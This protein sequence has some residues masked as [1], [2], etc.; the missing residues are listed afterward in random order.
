MYYLSANYYRGDDTN[1]YPYKWPWIIVIDTRKNTITTFK[2]DNPQN[3]YLNEA[4]RC[5][6]AL[7]V[8]KNNFWPD[9]TFDSDKT[10]LLSPYA[11]QGKGLKET[12]E[13]LLRFAFDV[14][15]SKGRY[16]LL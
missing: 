2:F 16:F 1:S 11:Q 8:E 4:N 14:L 7:S 5:N 3:K 10:I 15:S 13:C 9:N 12:P 6:S